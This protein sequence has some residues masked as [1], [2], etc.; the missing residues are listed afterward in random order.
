M[1]KLMYLKTV[2][3]IFFLIIVFIYL[4][5]YH[6]HLNIQYF[7]FKKNKTIKIALCVM[8]KNEQNYIIE[9]VDY[10]KKLGID[11]IFLYDNNNLNGSYYDKLLLDY[12][13]INFIDI[14]NFRGLYKPQYQAYEDCYYNNSNSY[15]WFAFF[16]VD[17]YLY[18]H[19]KIKNLL[20]NASLYNCSSL[21]INWKYYGDND[22]IYYKPKKL[23]QRFKKPFYFTYKKKK[24]IVLYTAG[25]TIAR[26]RLNI[27]WAHFPHFLKNS[28]ICRPN[29]K[30]INNP[31]LPPDYSMAYI[32]HYAT[33]STEEYA[34]K[35][36]KGGGCSK[37]TSDKKYIIG[38]IKNYYFFFN[39]VTNKKIELFEKKLNISI[40]KY[41][42]N[43]I[44]DIK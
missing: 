32:K 33:K 22:I 17:E 13:N 23:K 37:T 34:A 31:L 26:S 18:L 12:I 4:N 8:A 14:I 36:L 10:Y 3:F 43:I 5:T 1:N 39:K 7:V 44:F 24:N 16:D 28:N 40:R 2:K 19:D 38:R 20:I 9:F 11:K 6:M 30:I 21:L 42:D 15:D 27:S 25:K 29:G 35:L 41:Y